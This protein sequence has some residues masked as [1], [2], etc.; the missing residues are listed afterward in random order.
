MAR[1]M[2]LS[3]VWALGLGG[4]LVGGALAEEVITPAKPAVGFATTMEQ[5]LADVIAS[6]EKS[7]VAIA[8]VPKD[9]PGESFGLEFRPDPFG[10][11]ISPASPAKPM[12]ADFVPSDFATGV[13]VDRQGLILTAYHALGEDND[14]Y[15]TTPD[16]KIYRAW[17]KGADPRSD[18]AVLAIDATDL[19]PITFGD[20]AGL[21]KGQ[22]VIALGNPYAIARDGQASAS[23]GIVSNLA[24]KAPLSPDEVD[25]GGKS[26]L[27]H[28][29]TLIQTDAKL[30]LGTSGG[31]LVNL[32]G[33]MVGL[34]TSLAAMAGYEQAAGYAFPVDATMRRVVEILKQGR[35]VEYGLLGVRPSN[36]AA[37]ELLQGVQGCRVQGIVRGTPAERFGLRE[38]DLIVA[39]NGTRVFDADGLVLEV[40]RHPVE[41][42]VRLDV[43]REGK[44]QGIDVVLTKFPVRGKKIVTSPT[45]GWR[46]ARVDYPTA[47]IDAEAQAALGMPDFDDGVVVTEVEQGSPA[48][49]AGLR[50]KSLITQVDRVRIHN[51]REFQAAVAGK[52]GPV[53]V[54]LSEGLEANVVRT[55]G[56][57]S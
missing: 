55:I 30:T 27:H 53:Q 34:T 35:E 1:C 50:P 5:T 2:L 19:T 23:W 48:W 15:V 43:V 20:A 8:R 14:Y 18:L 40:G 12:D 37:Q 26:T 13:V 41:S 24:R 31:A 28:F 7:V 51:P 25:A 45:P 56:P 3:F 49:D 33:E 44:K 39:V 46:G 47:A 52:T 21:K 57:G 17:V 4:F 36:L 22:I 10:R 16:R 9:R 32:K 6:A 11:R 29:G 42:T 54:T 38:G